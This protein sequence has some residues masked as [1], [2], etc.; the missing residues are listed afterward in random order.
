MLH[1]EYLLDY[2]GKSKTEKTKHDLEKF[3][4]N[5]NNRG[6]L[7]LPMALIDITNSDKEILQIGSSVPNDLILNNFGHLM[8]AWIGLPLFENGFVDTGGTVRDNVQV[9]TNSSSNSN[10]IDR[11]IDFAEVPDKVTPVGTQ[12][13]LGQGISPPAR[14]DFD[15]QTP[16]GSAPE[17][18]LQNTNIGAWNS[19]LGKAIINRTYPNAVGSGIISEIGTFVSISDKL[20]PRLCMITHDLISPSVSYNAGQIINVEL[21]WQ[22]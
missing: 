22:L 11:G 21:S 18:S 16:L 1:N 14:T 20:S 8:N 9:V 6:G 12:F 4:S 2:I 5:K 19:G 17:S 15:I 13:R 3:V 10:A 7:G